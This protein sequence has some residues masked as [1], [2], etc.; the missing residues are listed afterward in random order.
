[1]DL[2]FVSVEIMGSGGLKWVVKLGRNIRCSKMRQ[3]ENIMLK[4]L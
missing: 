4:K 2:N 3:N 1:M